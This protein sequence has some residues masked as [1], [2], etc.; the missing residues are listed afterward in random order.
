MRIA[1]AVLALGSSFSARECSL[2]AETPPPAQA[3][4]SMTASLALPAPAYG[5]TVVAAEGAPV[6]VVVQDDGV[7]HAYP[8]EVESGV[9]VPA[10]ATVFVDVHTT[11]GQPRTAELEWVPAV[12]RFEGRVVGVTPAPGPLVVRVDIEG[13]VRRSPPVEVI[14]IRPAPEVHVHA[15]VARPRANVRAAVHVNAPPP[16]SV[17][18]DVDIP[19]P[20]SLSVR[21]GGGARVEHRTVVHHRHGKHRKHRKHRGH[22]RG[23]GHRH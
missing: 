12:H 7:V 17:R 8:L 10:E 19:R 15:D 22:G 3:A 20:P 5:G 18:V 1:L 21:I 9:A 13:R 16:P 4:A 6:E 23:R 11:A 14:V 2:M